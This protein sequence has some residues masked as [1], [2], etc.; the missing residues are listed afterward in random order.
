MQVTACLPETNAFHVR[1]GKDVEHLQ[2]VACMFL[3]QQSGLGFFSPILNPLAS[4]LGVLM[5]DHW[6][7]L[8]CTGASLG[9]AVLALRKSRWKQKL[10]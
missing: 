3:A 8:V 6:D 1:K 7:H 5:A 4:A 10:L 2:D 9:C